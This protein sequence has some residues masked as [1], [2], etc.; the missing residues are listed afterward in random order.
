ML[1]KMQVSILIILHLLF[2]VILLMGVKPTVIEL[3]KCKTGLF[4]NEPT[5]NGIAYIQV[6]VR[7]VVSTCFN[8]SLNEA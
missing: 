3:H 8:K 6:S 1:H 7:C 2:P 4:H 5:P